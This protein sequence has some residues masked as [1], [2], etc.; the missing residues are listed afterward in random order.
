A[1]RA[2]HL[3]VDC[4]ASENSVRAR[5]AGFSSL[6]WG[7]AAVCPV[8]RIGNAFEEGIPRK[9]ACF[10]YTLWR[11]G[12]S[13]LGCTRLAYLCSLIV[14]HIATVGFPLGVVQASLQELRIV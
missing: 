1:A 3:C 9:Q 4:A 2:K 12:P 5:A 7:S 6:V 14:R 10:V 11:Q 13:L 8:H